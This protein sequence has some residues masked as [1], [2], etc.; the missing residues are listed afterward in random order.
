MFIMVKMSTSVFLVVGVF[1]ALIICGMEGEK[2]FIYS[3]N[4]FIMSVK[5]YM[6]ISQTHQQT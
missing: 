3:Q 1:G 2:S 5:D 6:I 4:L